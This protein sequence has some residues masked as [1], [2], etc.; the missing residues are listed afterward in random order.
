MDDVPRC[1]GAGRC[2]RSVLFGLGRQLPCWDGFARLA[3]VRVQG[4]QVVDPLA[5]DQVATAGHV[6]WR[7]GATIA[8]CGLP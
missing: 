7:G 4:A 2:V 8:T 1:V 6:A 3:A 5:G